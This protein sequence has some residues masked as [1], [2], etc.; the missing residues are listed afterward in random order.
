[1]RKRRIKLFY[2]AS[3]FGVLLVAGWYGT[4]RF[5]SGTDE[6]GNNR[7][8]LDAEQFFALTNSAPSTSAVKRS[9]SIRQPSA[10]AASLS[11]QAAKAKV[12]AALPKLIEAINPDQTTPATHQLSDDKNLHLQRYENAYDLD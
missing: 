3:L 2:G 12:I 5:V 8:G 10:N 11:S 4:Q 9:P 6:V 7:T 1:M